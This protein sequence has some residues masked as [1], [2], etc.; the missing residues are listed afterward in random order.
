M[1]QAA[2][3]YAQVSQVALSPRDAEATVLIKAATRLQAIRD[4]WDGRRAD[5]D[6][7]LMFN[8][9]LWTILV[10]SATDETNPLPVAIKQNILNL[11]MFIFSQTLALGAS[12]DPAK[13]AALVNINREI[14]A[15]LRQTVPAAA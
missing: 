5:L 7:A 3:K 8:R 13:L 14:A 6:G 4:D 9:K 10:T 12:P 11:G 2:S 1:N 15:G